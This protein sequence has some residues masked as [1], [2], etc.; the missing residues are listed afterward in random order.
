[1]TRVIV[2]ANLPGKLTNLIQPVELCDQH[3]RVLGKFF[4]N[5]SP[6]EFDLEPQISK[7]ELERRKA[8]NERTYT[9]AEVLA[10]LERL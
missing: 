1:M 5:V 2:D 9:T 10:H 8:S 3:G 4:P 6:A 7:E